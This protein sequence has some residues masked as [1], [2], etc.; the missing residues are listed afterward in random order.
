VA[1][2]VVVVVFAAVAQNFKVRCSKSL[3]CCVKYVRQILHWYRNLNAGRKEEEE[4]VV[5]VVVV[6]VNSG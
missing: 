1:V 4:V 5:V 2:L 6:V 3:G